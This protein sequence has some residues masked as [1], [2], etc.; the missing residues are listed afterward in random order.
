MLQMTSITV[1]DDAMSLPIRVGRG[2][3]AVALLGFGILH[4]VFGDVV[5]GRSPDWPEGLPGQQ[6]AAILTA[7]LLA[8]AAVVTFFGKRGR[9]VL[10]ALAVVV[11]VWAFL[12]HIP[13]VLEAP[14]FGGQWTTMGKAMVLTGGILAMAAR[15]PEG[16][17]RRAASGI[18]QTRC[19]WTPGGSRSGCS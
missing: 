16:S 15:F 19:S 12:R 4:V 2:L 9:G 5:I 18:A 7:A 17:A 6:V 13:V 8:V 10:W 14:V 3:F 1:E 11:F